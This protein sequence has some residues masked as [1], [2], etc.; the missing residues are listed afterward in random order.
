MRPTRTRLL[1]PREALTGYLDSL[2][3]DAP[4]LVAEAAETAV[5]NTV[6]TPTAALPQSSI[7]TPLTA[8]ADPGRCAVIRVGRLRL[9]LP[10]TELYGISAWPIG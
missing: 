5:T 6:E 3:R 4:A 8:P 1:D 2:F 9:A 7:A 10:L